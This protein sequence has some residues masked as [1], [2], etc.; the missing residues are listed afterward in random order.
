MIGP[1]PSGL[2]RQAVRS[3]R[4]PDGDSWHTENGRAGPQGEKDQPSFD[5]RVGRREASRAAVSKLVC[6]AGPK[7]TVAFVCYTVEGGYP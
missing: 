4:P 6:V 3:K 7:P 5:R 1:A 2:Q